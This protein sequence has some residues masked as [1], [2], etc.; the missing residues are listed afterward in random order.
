MAWLLDTNVLS[1][2]RKGGRAD[3]A[4]QAWFRDA[5][6]AD[7]FTSVL[8]LGEIRRGITR[9]A[10]RDPVGAQSLERWLRGLAESFSNRIL[11]VTAEVADLWGRLSSRQPLAPVDG[12]LA[13]T[14]LDRGLILVTRNVSDFARA[15]VSV[16]N[17]FG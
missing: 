6:D 5:P 16:L 3:P 8:V 12:L 2:L 15:D 11:P 17:P 1:E 14:A 9:L 13:A 4:V 7:L 10:R